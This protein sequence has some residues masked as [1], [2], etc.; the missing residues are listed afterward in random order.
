MAKHIHIPGK[1]YSA[2]GQVLNEAVEMSDDDQRDMRK[3]TR[4]KPGA[5][6]ALDKAKAL[7]EKM[8]YSEGWGKTTGYDM[9]SIEQQCNQ[10]YQ[11]IKRNYD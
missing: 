11:N 10:L 5:I 6:A 7:I 1:E 2:E 9:S 8:E 4:A 3:F